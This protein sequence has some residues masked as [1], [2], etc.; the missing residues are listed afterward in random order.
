M[1]RFT[2]SAESEITQ[3]S[4]VVVGSLNI[5]LVI[6]LERMPNSGETVLGD[7]LVRLAG[8]K[9]LNQAVAA[10]RMDAPVRMIGCVGTD[11][12]GDWLRGIL[13]EEGIDASGVGSVEG[14]SGTALIEVESNGANRIVVVPGANAALTAEAVEAALRAVANPA[15]VLTQAEIPLEAISAA[16]TTG[17]ELGATTILNPAPAREFPAEILARVDYLVPNEHEAEHM[18][19]IGCGNMVD[20]VEAAGTFIDKGVGCAVITRGDRGAVWANAN[21]S[22]QVQAFRVNTV[23]TVAAGDAFCGGLAAALASGETLA[24]ALRWA[25]GCGALAT[26]VTGA[27][28]SL[29]TRAAVAELIGEPDSAR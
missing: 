7:S 12:S 29:P 13:A 11:G 10:A 22:G 23:D 17:K 9:G 6:G 24:E 5:D 28:P 4:V 25:S 14:T 20:S 8:G 15:V 16:L 1:G 21:S 2:I 19:G 18:C 27:V 26:T 3:G